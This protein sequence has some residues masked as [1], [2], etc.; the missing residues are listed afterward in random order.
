MPY[1]IISIEF[2]SFAWLRREIGGKLGY[3]FDE[4]AWGH[5]QSEHVNAIIQRGYMQMLYPPPLGENPSHQ[6]S[7]LSPLA[8]LSLVA[9]QEDYELP[10]NFSGVLGQFTVQAT[11][12]ASLIPI[13][14]ELQLR[15]LASSSPQNGT[16]KYAA[17]RPV[18]SDHSGRQ[19]WLAIFYPKPNAAL[20][21]E[22]RYTVNPGNLSE[23]QPYPMGGKQYAECLLASCLS[24]AMEDSELAASAVK[25]FS[26]RLAAAI[27]LDV[28]TAVPTSEG[29]WPLRDIEFGTYQWLRREI[30]GERGYG[31]NEAAWTHEQSEHVKAII[32]RGYQQMLYPPPIAVSEGESA[33][34]H[35]WSFLAPLATLTVVS[36]QREYELPNDFSGV[37]GQFTV[38]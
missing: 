9:D 25:K 21:L 6:W 26:N 18:Q 22:Y 3:G 35:Q 37:L 2:G 28:Q 32:Q 7:F 29:M 14:P 27:Q 10:D 13:V 31:Y 20:T 23:A 16:P 38:V 34:P 17:I 19:K 33:A 11:G 30:G 36:G 1:P 8:V 4:S 5:E 15:Q 24:C 12:S